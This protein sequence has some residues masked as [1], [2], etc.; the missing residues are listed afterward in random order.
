[1]GKNKDCKED[2][3]TSN[4]VQ[5]SIEVEDVEDSFEGKEDLDT[6][7]IVQDSLE[8]EDSMKDSH[9]CLKVEEVEWVEDSF[10]GV[11]D[12][13]NKAKKVED[14][15]DSSLSNTIDELL[16]NQKSLAKFDF[17]L[18]EPAIEE[19]SFEGID[20]DTNKAKKVEDSRDSSLSN[21][22]DELVHNQKSLAKFDFDLNEPAIDDEEDGAIEG[23]ERQEVVRS[24]LKILLP[25]FY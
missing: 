14:S 17:D 20:D 10:E 15:G 18:N 24:M 4:I 6:S 3:D 23:K 11:D 2:L 7:N 1:M 22:I 19:D 25:K 5:D 8:V 12:D 16:H 9:D 21:T 13:T